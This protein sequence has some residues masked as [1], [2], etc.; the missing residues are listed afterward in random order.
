MLF[1]SALAKSRPDDADAHANLGNV[2]LLTGRAKEAVER[3][4]AALRLRPGDERLRESLATARRA[5]S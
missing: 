3:F 2:L 5:G 4:E 1:R